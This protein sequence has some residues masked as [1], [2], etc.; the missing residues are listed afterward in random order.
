MEGEKI[1]HL[2]HCIKIA[3]GLDKFKVH[4][5]ILHQ[6]ISCHCSSK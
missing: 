5:M 4:E 2:I 3:L 6:L 1:P